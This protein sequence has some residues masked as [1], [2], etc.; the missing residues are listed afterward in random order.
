MVLINRSLFL[1]LV[2]I[3]LAACGG[4]PTPARYFRVAVIVDTATDP[5][6]REQVEAVL[7]IANDRLF[8]LT[9]FGIQL[10]GFAE[11][12][13]GAPIASL[14]ENYMRDETSLPNGIL[15]FSVGDDDRARNNR[16]YAQQVPAPDGFRNAF[17]SPYLGDTYM[18]V[19]VLQFNYRYA[20]CGY[21]GTDTIQS[22]VSSHG[23]CR[24]F[25]GVPCVGWNGTQVCESALEFLEGH[26]PI[27]LAA[28]PVIHEFMHAFGDRGAEDHYTSDA[29]K[30]AMGRP[31]DH[32]DLEE[33]EYYSD[34]CPDVYAVFADSYKP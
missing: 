10:V 4:P 33:A 2:L 34:F 24:G 27:D 20:A 17:V 26:T 31:P 23:E 5:V 7:A 21:A 32:Y 16:A 29:C 30:T 11:D 28:G 19:A 9:G 22:A 14:V 15:V 12:G 8:D 1:P 25:D 6:S 13:S 18:Y 3:V